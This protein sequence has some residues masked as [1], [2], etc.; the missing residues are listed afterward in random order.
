MHI[1]FT[2]SSLSHGGA[3]RVASILANHWCQLGHEVTFIIQAAPQTKPHYKRDPSINIRSTSTARRSGG[4]LRAITNNLSR[5]K[6]LRKHIKE[7]KAD[8]IVSFIDT[9]NVLT[10]LASIGVNS[11]VIISERVDP[12]KHSIGIMWKV[13]RYLTYPL[14]D[15]LVLQTENLLNYFP[16]SKKRTDLVIPNP[17]SNE[18]TIAKLKAKK[19]YQLISLGRLVPQKGFDLLIKAF[20]SIAKDIPQWRLNI[21]G[22]GPQED[23]LKRLIKINKLENAASIIP[24]TSEPLKK[25]AESDLYI[26]SSRF[27]GFPNGLLEA[28]A[29]GLP[30]IAT[31]CPSGPSGMIENNINGILIESESVDAMAASIKELANSLEKR[32]QL[33]KHAK[34]VQTAYSAATIAEKWLELFHSL[35]RSNK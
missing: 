32:M 19:N 13:L 17:V 9:N 35:N 8:Y 16:K 22:D 15:A 3:E 2:I 34:K 21:Y 24:S 5:I 1:A 12:R 31:N 27:E 28:M 29:S 4:L 25:L 7:S 30:V 33:A 26:L 23:E 18:C 10:L 6:S 20:A 14:A 11:P